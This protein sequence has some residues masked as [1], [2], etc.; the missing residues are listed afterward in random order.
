MPKGGVNRLKFLRP[1][2]LFFTCLLLLATT[3]VVTAQTTSGFRQSDLTCRA[4]CSAPNQSD[5]LVHP[6]GV[7]FLAHQNFFIAENGAGT[8]DGY[9]IT[10]V[11]SSSVTIPLPGGST[12]GVSKPT[13]IVVDPDLNIRIGRTAFELFAATQEGTIVGFTFQNGAPSQ[14][15]IIVDHSLSAEFTGLTLLHPTCCNPVLAAANFH[16]GEIEV[17][18]PSQIAL[19]GAFEDPNLPAGYAPFNIQTIGNQVFVTFAKQD[20]SRRTPVAGDGLGIVSVFD[21]DGNFI[22]RFVSNGGN[23]NAPW[24]ITATSAN[25]GPFANDILIGNAGDGRIDVYDPATAEF[26]GP[27][28]DGEQKPISNAELRG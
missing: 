1:H 18:G 24:G 7:S 3:S 26:L 2:V 13:G 6:W 16:D 15:A 10:G 28:V 5:S 9:D 21:Q 14:A 20:E 27:L 17:F 8:V 11:L 25:F 22:R 23:L 19:P 12:A 4:Q